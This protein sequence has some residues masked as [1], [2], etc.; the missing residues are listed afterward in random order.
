MADAS[1]SRPPV[2]N[3]YSSAVFIGWAC[4]LFAIVLEQ[5]YR[6]GLGNIV[7]SV[8]GFLT[9]LV[10]H[11]LSPRRRHFRCTTGGARYPILA[12]HSCRVH[13]AGLCHHVLGRWTWSTLRTFRLCAA[14]ARR[15]TTP[16]SADDLWHALLRY[17]LQFRRY[18]P[19]RSMG[20][21]LVGPLLGLGPQGERRANHR[22][23]QR[24]CTSRP[25]GRFGRRPWTRTLA[26][27]GNIITTWSWFGVNALGVGL[28]A[29]GANDSSTA[30]WLLTFVASQLGLIVLGTLPHQ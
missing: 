4:V 15:P 8:I 22:P 14:N 17:L 26:I 3:L 2:T 1:A 10:A 11:F 20:R 29:Y 9:L 21:R 19:G 12:C 27:G 18:S 23:L 5:V 16:T 6:L 30:M 7:A 28:H 24:D 13:N 25:L